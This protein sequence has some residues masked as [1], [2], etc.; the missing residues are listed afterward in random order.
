MSLSPTADVL[1]VN[2]NQRCISCEVAPQPMPPLESCRC[3]II[4]FAQLRDFSLTRHFDYQ[5]TAEE[6]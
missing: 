6:K 2:S 3:G 1:N 4:A 5:L